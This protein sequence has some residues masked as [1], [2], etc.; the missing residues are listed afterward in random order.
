M[1]V[2]LKSTSIFIFCKKLVTNLVIDIYFSFSN[3]SIKEINN[4]SS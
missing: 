3:V 1:L 4:K 2:L